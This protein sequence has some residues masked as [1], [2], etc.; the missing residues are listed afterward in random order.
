MLTDLEIVN[1][2]VALH[3]PAQPTGYWDFLWPIDG[4][5][6]ALKRAGGY[7]VVVWRGSTTPLDWFEDLVSEVPI[8]DRELGHCAG[9]FLAGMRGAQSLVDAEITQPVIVTGHSLGAAHAAPYA[10]HLCAQGCPPVALVNFGEP[11]PGFERVRDLLKDVPARSYRNRMDP[12]TE[13]PVLGTEKFD[14]YVHSRELTPLS[15]FPPDPDSWG[16]VADH[17]LDLYQRG[18]MGLAA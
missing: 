10:A 7:D 4:S 16:D 11:R 6:C 9:G 13:V 14:L 8:W 17:H 3:Q 5:Y 15:V 1:I 12:V 18:I 2:C